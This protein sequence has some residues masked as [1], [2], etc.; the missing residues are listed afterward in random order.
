MKDTLKSLPPIG[1]DDPAGLDAIAPIR[2]YDPESG[3]QWFPSEFD[4]D[5]LLFGMVLG[6]E[7]EFGSF[8]LEEL[9]EAGVILDQNYIPTKFAD[10]LG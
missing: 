10:L 8:S 9:I 3:W 5:D 7:T 4:G 1:T 2:L 6:A